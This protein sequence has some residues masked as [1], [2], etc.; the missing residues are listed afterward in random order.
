MGVRRLAAPQARGGHRAA[1]AADSG[2]G[3]RRAAAGGGGPDAARARRRGAAVRPRR[4]GGAGPRDAQAGCRA[5]GRQV[6]RRGR[7]GDG[8]AHANAQGGQRAVAER[9]ARGGVAALVQAHHLQAEAG[10]AGMEGGV[11]AERGLGLSWPGTLP[12]KGGAPDGGRGPP[13]PAAPDLMRSAAAGCSSMS[14]ELALPRPVW[15][16]SP[17]KGL[18]LR[19]GAAQGDSK[20]RKGVG[21]PCVQPLSCGAR[22]RG[23]A[24]SGCAR[25]PLAAAQHVACKAAGL[26]GQHHGGGVTVQSLRWVRWAGRGGEAAG[27]QVRPPVNNQTGGDGWLACRGAARHPHST[28]HQQP[29]VVAIGRRHP[30]PAAQ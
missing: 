29:Q 16:S 22:P 19:L 1:A 18:R 23:L 27:Q 10:A 28:D 25:R 13:Q 4:A 11:G 12:C 15:P 3:R 14:P 2:G 30:L 6:R 8:R 7:Q 24:L 9:Q 20:G 17:R 5:A 26:A 21:V